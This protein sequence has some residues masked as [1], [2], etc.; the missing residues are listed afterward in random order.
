MVEK[1]L[2]RAIFLES[3]FLEKGNAGDA[4]MVDKGYPL[5]GLDFTF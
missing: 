5:K 1:P 2:D 3:K 4:I